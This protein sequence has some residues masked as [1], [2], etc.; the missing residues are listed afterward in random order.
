[1]KKIIILQTAFF[2]LGLLQSHSQTLKTVRTYRN[3]FNTV[4]YEVYT[5]NA[6]TG[7]KHGTYHL[8]MEDGT[9]GMT[10][11]YANGARNGAYRQYGFANGNATD[12][13]KARIEANYL[14]DKLHGKYVHYMLLNGQRRPCT[15]RVYDKG[16]IVQ[17]TTYYESNGV[18]KEHSCRDGVA[19]A[20]FENGKVKRECP[21]TNGK[22]NG[23]YVEYYPDGTLAEASYYK[24]G[25][26]DGKLEEYYD[27]GKLR[28]TQQFINGLFTG[29]I[30]GYRSNGKLAEKYIYETPGM[31]SSCIFY[32]DNGS[33]RSES[34]R[35]GDDE[36]LTIRYDSIS[37][38][39]IAEIVQT[40]RQA[41]TFSDEGSSS[42]LYRPDGT[43]QEERKCNDQ[44]QIRR[45]I[46]NAEGHLESVYDYDKTQIYVFSGTETISKRI[47]R[48]NHKGI[49]SY[50]VYDREGNVIEKG[51]QDTSGTVI[52]S[53]TYVDGIR[54]QSLSADGRQNWYYPNGAIKYV[55]NPG[56]SC[57]LKYDEQGRLIARSS[58]K[59]R[60][61][62]YNYPGTMTIQAK[63][64]EDAEG[65]RIGKW[66]LYSETGLL[67]IEENGIVRKPTKEEKSNHASYLQEL[68][69]AKL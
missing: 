13:G 6:T 1:M 37:A 8:Y 53:N 62:V 67:S 7:Q 39:K 63:G 18:K 28:T 61:F 38:S 50:E 22:P 52:N 24:N 5:V 10:M 33:K 40:W 48:V 66:Y 54:V 55:Y 64:Q 35:T 4:P 31:C 32:F 20:W 44:K 12:Q 21:M 30:I 11:T 58:V 27:D 19:N 26:L 17:E 69:N 23:K 51:E 60:Y 36:F 3:L 57:I 68:V 43:L 34:T 25:E 2:L 47:Q 56:S 14:N 65:N 45:S 29:E 49:C 15:E 41:A 9:L 59:D 42:K 16:E 46:Y